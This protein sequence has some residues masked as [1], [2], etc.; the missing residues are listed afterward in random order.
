MLYMLQFIKYRK[1]TN[2]GICDRVSQLNRY[3][4]YTY[5]IAF[6]TKTHFIKKKCHSKG[7][8][9][10]RI[11]ENIMLEWKMRNWAIYFL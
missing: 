7:K 2:C 10:H 1:P 8:F 9:I 4:D 6:W 5:A 11:L 3:F